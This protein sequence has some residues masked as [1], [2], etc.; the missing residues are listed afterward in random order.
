MQITNQNQLRKNT[1]LLNEI[2]NKRNQFL[3]QR[4]R[5][6]TFHHSNKSGKYLAS[7]IKRN[8]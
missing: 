3:I 8:K 4:L 6:E 1:F 7:Q 2:I 5:Q